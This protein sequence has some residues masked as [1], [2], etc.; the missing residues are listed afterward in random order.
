M[1]RS[2]RIP[3]KW[4]IY[5][6][7]PLLLKRSPGWITVRVDTIKTLHEPF[8]KTIINR[9]YGYRTNALLGNNAYTGPTRLASTPHVGPL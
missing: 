4:H 7:L 9:T 2:P 6:I 5:C 3:P 8:L 1:T